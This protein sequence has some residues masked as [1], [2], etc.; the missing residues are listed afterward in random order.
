MLVTLVTS[1]LEVAGWVLLILFVIIPLAL[2][3]I[4]ALTDLFLAPGQRWV[5]S[6]DR[7]SRRGSAR[8]PSRTNS[9]GGQGSPGRKE[10]AKMPRRDL[11]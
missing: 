8:R 9:G 5:I 2:L 11:R 4:Y 3:W 6:V 1:F 10:P 7:G